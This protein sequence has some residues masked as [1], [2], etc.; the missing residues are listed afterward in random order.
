LE[1]GKLTVTVKSTRKRDNIQLL[2][3]I[4]GVVGVV[5]DRSLEAFDYPICIEKKVTFIA[6][7]RG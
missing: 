7:S 4:A 1:K 5:C 6:R 2:F 3:N